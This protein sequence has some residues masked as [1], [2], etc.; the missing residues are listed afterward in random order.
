MF[1]LERHLSSCLCTE[2]VTIVHVVPAEAELDVEVTEVMIDWCELSLELVVE[3]I[4]GAVSIEINIHIVAAEFVTE[5][6]PCET[7]RVDGQFG[8]CLQSL[9]QSH[10]N[11]GA[12]GHGCLKRNVKAEL[13]GGIFLGV[14]A[15]TGME[16]HRLSIACREDDTHTVGLLPY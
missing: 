4:I 14:V 3:N 1:I 2:C 5:P 12:H 9:T 7:A 11:I 10:G 8:S 6:G 16:L 15:E 13:D